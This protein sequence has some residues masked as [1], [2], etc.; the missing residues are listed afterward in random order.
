[1]FASAGA[2]TAAASEGAAR[3]TVT[4]ADLRAIMKAIKAPGAR[5]VLVNV[6]ATWCDPCRAEIP[7]LLRY[8]RENRDHGVRLVLVS[9]DDEA[10]RADVERFLTAS[11]FDGH[12]FIKHGDNAALIKALDPRW[13]G[14][15]PTTFMFDGAG[16]VLWFWAEPLTHDKLQEG[17]TAMLARARARRA[18]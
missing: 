11:G 16:K 1:L 8:Y 10:R 2:A 9:A 6:W 7:E 17:V 13:R 15:L 18:R 3:P 14:T 12:A 4:V 5:V